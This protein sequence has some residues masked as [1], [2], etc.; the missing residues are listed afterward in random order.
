MPLK[1]PLHSLVRYKVIKKI[2]KMALD[3]LNFFLAPNHGSD[4]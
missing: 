2:V 4:T 1:H 3:W